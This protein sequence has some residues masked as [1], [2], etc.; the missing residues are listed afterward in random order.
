MS[1]ASENSAFEHERLKEAINDIKDDA[2]ETRESVRSF[3][4]DFAQA[5]GDLKEALLGWKADVE[6]RL[7]GYSLRIAELEEKAKSREKTIAERA[8]VAMNA[9][10]VALVLYVLYK[11]TGI[12]TP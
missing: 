9:I 1:P 12:K 7:A 2:K 3:G 5:L 6:A 4:R 8:N 10:L 11:V